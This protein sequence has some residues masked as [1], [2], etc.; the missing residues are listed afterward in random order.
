MKHNCIFEDAA[1]YSPCGRRTEP[2][3]YYSS[4]RLLNDMDYLTHGEIDERAV[5]PVAVDAAGDICTS[6]CDKVMDLFLACQSVRDDEG[7]YDILVQV[8]SRLDEDVPLEIR[9]FAALPDVWEMFARMTADEVEILRDLM[10]GDGQADEEDVWLDL[11]ED[12]DGT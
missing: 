6:C 10:N 9:A 7:A 8:Y 11:D 2:L 4:I 12:G 1:L 5:Y 3:N